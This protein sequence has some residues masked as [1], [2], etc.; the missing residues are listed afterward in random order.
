MENHMEQKVETG[1]MRGVPLRSC[2][3]SLWSVAAIVR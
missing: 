1:V 2:L 3:A